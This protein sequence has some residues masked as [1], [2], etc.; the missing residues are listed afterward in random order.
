MEAIKVTNANVRVIE[1]TLLTMGSPPFPLR[2]SRDLCHSSSCLQVSFRSS[3][4]LKIGR[5][6]A[7]IKSRGHWKQWVT[8]QKGIKKWWRQCQ[9]APVESIG[10]CPYPL[11]KTASRTARGS[12]VGKRGGSQEGAKSEGLVAR[13]D[14]SRRPIVRTGRT[15]ANGFMGMPT[16][17]PHSFRVRTNPATISALSRPNYRVSRSGDSQS[18]RGGRR[19]SCQVNA[20]ERR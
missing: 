4:T 19:A 2:V 15:Q 10:E 3:Y 16:L 14:Y 5:R 1:R 8:H 6:P 17:I 13:G 18:N 9:G 12:G 20:G 7:R 11:E